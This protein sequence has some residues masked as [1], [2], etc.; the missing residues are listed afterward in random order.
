MV[1]A[2]VVLHITYLAVAGFAVMLLCGIWA[3]VSWRHLAGGTA[4][5]GDAATRRRPGRSRGR[6]RRPSRPQAGIMER[7]DERWRRRQEG[8]R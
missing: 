4:T 3:L 8:G 1:A 7:F 6:K 2:G 5:Q